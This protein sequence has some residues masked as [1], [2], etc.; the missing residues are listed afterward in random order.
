QMLEVQAAIDVAK[1]QLNAAQKSYTDLASHPTEAEQT[2]AK[3]R[4]AVAESGMEQAQVAYNRVRGDPQLGSLPESM[5]LR[6]MTAAYEAA[7]AEAALTTQG[8][9]QEQL[10]VAASAI[11]EA[12]A[13]VQAAASKAPGAEA[14]VKSALARQASAQATLDHLRAGATPDEIAMAQAQL[15]SAQAALASAQAQL[16]QGR[17]FAPFDGQI[18]EVNVR[19]GELTT[20]GQ[21][22][23]LLGDTRRMLVKTTDLR[24]TDVVHLTVGMPVEVTFDALPGRTFN[25]TITRIAPVSTAEKGST[26]YTVQV[27]VAELD[28]Q[29]RWGMTAF[30][31]IQ[32]DGASP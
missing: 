3:A 2:A 28:P 9:T 16:R 29:L 23:L 25:G 5:T 13:Q 12:R 22:A 8:A 27:E 30:V 17:L 20:P 18:G 10:A 31:N 1:A 7:N 15:Q 4:V 6:Q 32:T 26:N 21:Y 11:Q 24:E 19:A 14:A